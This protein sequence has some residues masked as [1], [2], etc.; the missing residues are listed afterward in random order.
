[1]F[2]NQFSMFGTLAM[3][4]EAY[5]YH[6]DLADA[7]AHRT[8]LEQVCKQIIEYINTL[9]EEDRAE[10]S[11]SVGAIL[12]SHHMALIKKMTYGFLSLKGWELVIDGE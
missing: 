11:W 4:I 5:E 6:R 12:E 9:P 1:M 10:A 8:E 2:T 7:I 3:A